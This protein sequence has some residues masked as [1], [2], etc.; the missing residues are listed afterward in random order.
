MGHGWITGRPGRSRV[1]GAERRRRHC[2]GLAL[3]PGTEGRPG[4]ARRKPLVAGE[5]TADALICSP[6][7]G[8]PLPALPFAVE[9]PAGWERFQTLV[10]DA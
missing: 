5:S 4:V 2:S 3:G 1:T 7:D 6:R 10:I 8:R 9:Q